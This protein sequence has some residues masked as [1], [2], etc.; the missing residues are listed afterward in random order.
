[1]FRSL[2][3]G[4]TI[5]KDLAEAPSTTVIPAQDSI[6]AD[7]LNLDLTVPSLGNVLLKNYFG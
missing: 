1:M 7:L 4:S 2:L 5:V 6:I 3:E